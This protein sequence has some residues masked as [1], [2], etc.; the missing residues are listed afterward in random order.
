MST[1]A[2][3]P[4]MIL[5]SRGLTASGKTRFALNGTPRPALLLD[6]DYGAEGLAEDVLAGV[7]QRQYD[8]LA[9][10]FRGESD[11]AR[12]QII[13]N[14]VERFL[15]DFRAAVDGKI[16]ASKESGYEGLP[17]RHIVVDTASVIW[18]G[19]RLRHRTEK[20]SGFDEAK[21]VFFSLI[22]AAYKSDS[23]NLTL[24]HHMTTAWAKSSSGQ[25]YKKEG[26]YEMIGLEE[27]INKVQLAVEHRWVAPI[28]NVKAGRFETV[29]VKCRENKPL[30]GEIMEAPDWV[31][32]CSVVAP[33]VDWSA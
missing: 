33:S 27:A 14:E 18:T 11:Q 22:R 32:L 21:E 26:V 1:I 4:R 30:E 10:A 12:A 7:D 3:Q 8:L 5:L 31:T 17:Y 23:I 15:A 16:V 19:L 29:I 24:I 25:A 13:R 9:G 2:R 6:S 28:P 20:S